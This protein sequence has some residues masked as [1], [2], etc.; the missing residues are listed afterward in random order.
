MATD[1]LTKI[2]TDEGDFI[3]LTKI[4]YLGFLKMPRSSVM[5]FKTAQFLAIPGFQIHYN[6]SDPNILREWHEM[7]V[8]LVQKGFFQALADGARVGRFPYPDDM[9]HL[10]R[11]VKRFV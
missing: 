1:H 5:P 10:Q 11:F 8:A 3:V 2:E 4:R 6:T 7:I 9:K